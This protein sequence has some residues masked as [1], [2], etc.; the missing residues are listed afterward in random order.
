LTMLF[1]ALA[2]LLATIGLYG[3]TA[4]T[5][6][7]RTSEIGIRMALG[8]ERTDVLCMVITRGMV[9]TAIGLGIGFFVSLAL[10]RLLASFLFGVS[11]TDWQIF[12]GISMAL[13]AAAILA[14]Y[15]PAHRATRVDPVEALRYE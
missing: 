9:V 1:G 5:V 10:A 6:A 7:R 4:Y 14:C 15:V 11:A 13:A 2:L 12:G 3:V 8:A